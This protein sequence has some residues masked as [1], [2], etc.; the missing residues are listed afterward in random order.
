MQADIVLFPFI[1]RFA[2]CAPRHAGYDVQAACGGAIGKW[3]DA[4][5]A[6]QSCMVSCANSDALLQAYRCTHCLS[7]FCTEKGTRSL[8]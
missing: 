3:L 6:R 5:S 8:S 7:R 4:M 2:L 1:D